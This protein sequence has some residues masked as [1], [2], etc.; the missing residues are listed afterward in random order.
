MPQGAEKK[1]G[2]RAIGKKPCSGL[3]DAIR[4]HSC[5]TGPGQHTKKTKSS[6]LSRKDTARSIAGYFARFA[7]GGP[8]WQRQQQWRHQLLHARPSHF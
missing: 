4:N 5:L 8:E 1:D 3:H 7:G 2:P 6:C